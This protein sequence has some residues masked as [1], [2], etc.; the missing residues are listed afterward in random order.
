MI[1]ATINS[2]LDDKF[3]SQLGN[4]QVIQKKIPFG[5]SCS[6][7]WWVF[8][9]HHFQ[10]LVLEISLFNMYKIYTV[11]TQQ[12]N[13]NSIQVPIDYIPGD[14]GTY[15]GTENKVQKFHGLRV[16]KWYRVCSPISVELC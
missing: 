15:P 8:L 16:L 9:Q 6:I 2:I 11:F 5:V 7:L 1:I 13:T 3:Y 12:Q 14:T 10:S 4:I